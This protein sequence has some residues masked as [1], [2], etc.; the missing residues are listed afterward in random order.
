M[1]STKKCKNC[2]ADNDLFFTNCLYCKSPLPQVDLN[3][4]SNEELLLK[5]GEWVGKVGTHFQHITENFNSFTGKGMIVI[6]AN[7]IEGMAQKYLTLLQMRGMNNQNLMVAYQSLKS[8]FDEK[9]KGVIYK[10]GGGDK[11][12]GM[13]YIFAIIIFLIFAIGSI[14]IL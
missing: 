13:A 2:G 14:F 6:S 12:K 3:S 5:A 7:E 11:M 10:I 8:E 4:I 9:R 1:S